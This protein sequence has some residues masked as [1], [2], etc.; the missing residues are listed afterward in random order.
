LHATILKI[1]DTDCQRLYT[2]VRAF[3][4]VKGMFKA[5]QSAIRFI[6]RLNWRYAEIGPGSA[7]SFLARVRGHQNIFLGSNVIVRQGAE[8]DATNGTVRLGDNVIICSGAKILTYG[9]NIILG[10]DCT[11]NPYV[12]LYGHGNLRIG[13]SVRIAA[14]TIV[15]PANHKFDRTDVPIW[16]Q[17]VNR[18]GIEIGNDV[19]IGSNACILDGVNIGDGVVVGAGSVVTCN[20]EPRTVVGGVPARVLKRR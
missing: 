20:I 13:D 16:R 6:T 14:G 3:T 8:I 18:L 5:I 17:G 2:L 7:V 19:W 11:V 4:L 12:I 9:G 15:I 10:K 1:G